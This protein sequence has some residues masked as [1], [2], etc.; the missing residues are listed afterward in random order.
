MVL[1]HAE[2]IAE[3]K[4]SPIIESLSSCPLE[5][6]RRIDGLASESMTSKRNVPSLVG[7]QLGLIPIVQ[8]GKRDLIWTS[9]LPPRGP[10]H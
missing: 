10:P 9:Q 7:N 2:P 3:E 4:K 8:M 5:T 6:R 1:C